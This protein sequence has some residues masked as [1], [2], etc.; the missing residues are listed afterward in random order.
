MRLEPRIIL[1]LFLNFSDFEPHYC[2]KLYSYKKECTVF[3][4]LTSSMTV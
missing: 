1:N 3:T 2:Y 4:F